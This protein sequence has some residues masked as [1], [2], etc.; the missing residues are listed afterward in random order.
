M[1][2]PNGDPDENRPRIDRVTKKNYVTVN[3]IAKMDMSSPISKESIN[4]I[5]SIGLSYG[6]MLKRGYLN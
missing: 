3:E 1:S 6:S 2:N 5:F 4:F